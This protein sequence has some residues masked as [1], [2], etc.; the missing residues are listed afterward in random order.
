MID[1][2]CVCLNFLIVWP[3]CDNLRKLCP[4]AFK[5]YMELKL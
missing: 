4:S 5:Q 3:D 1:M 2:L